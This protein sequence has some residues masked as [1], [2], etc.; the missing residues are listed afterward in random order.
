MRNKTIL[1]FLLLAGLILT[2]ACALGDLAQT[3]QPTPGSAG[4]STPAPT[5]VSERLDERLEGLKS[6]RAALKMK[7]AGVDKTGKQFNSTLDVIEEINRDQD[8]H[9]LLSHS[10]LAGER[11]GSVDIYQSG[12]KVYMVSSEEQDKQSGCTLLTPDKLAG[13][14]KLT[15]RP[16]D[17]YASLWRGN[18]V[19]LDEQLPNYVA[20]HYALGGADLRLGSAEKIS[21]DL[22]FSKDN[23][24]IVRFTGSAEGILSLGFGTTYGKI[25]WEYNLAG[26]NTTSIDLPPDCAALA[27]NDLPIPQDAL[28]VNQNGQQTAFQTAA[29]PAAALE[30]LRS[31]LKKRGWTVQNGARAGDTS[32]TYVVKDQESLVITITPLASGAKVVLLHK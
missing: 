16:T 8:I 10:N 25:D 2:S 14:T 3:D 13:R 32:V 15:L 21:G 1:L 26:I 23:G 5:P 18:L 31:E 17:L 20:D 27:R 11:P 30:F 7:F 9:H 22:W 29:A 4:P 24:Y 19:A 28:E 12:G 6:Y